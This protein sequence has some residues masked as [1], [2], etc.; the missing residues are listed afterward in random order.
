[1]KIALCPGSFDPV[2]LGHL[3]IIERAAKLFDTVCVCA[4]VNAEKPEGLFSFDERLELLRLAVA[5]YGNVKAAMWDGLCI[6]YA[7]KLGACALVKGVRTAE[8][9]RYEL[10]MAAWNREHAPDIETL[11]LPARDGLSHISATLVRKRFSAGESINDLV[12]PTCAER[13]QIL[14]GR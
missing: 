2:T 7:R 10:A 14:K 3:D 1:M 11:L 6:D 12:P 13:M 5:P 8:D 9:L 4:M